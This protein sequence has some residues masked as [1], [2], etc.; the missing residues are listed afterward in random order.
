MKKRTIIVGAA[1][2]GLTAL[3]VMNGNKEFPNVKIPQ[4]AKPVPAFYTP[5]KRDSFYEKEFIRAELKRTASYKIK[6]F[7]QDLERIL[8]ARMILGEAEDCSEVERV[9]VA[10]TA[11]NRMKE[12]DGRERLTDLLLKPRQYSCFNKGKDSNKFLKDPIKYNKKQFLEDVRIAE[13]VLLRRYNDPTKGATHYYNPDLIKA[14][15]WADKSKE[16]GKIGHHIFF[17]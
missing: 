10:Y 11:I 8:L 3:T 9:A 7:K 1:I 16:I 5:V 17:K 13:N 15:D 12:A 2:L 6:D 14:P 4:S